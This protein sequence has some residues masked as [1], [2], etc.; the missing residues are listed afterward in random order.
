MPRPRAFS[1]ARRFAGS[2]A[3]EEP[4]SELNITPLIDVMLV[5]LVMMILTLPTVLHKVALDLPQGSAPPSETVTHPLVLARNGTVTLDGM[6]LTDAAMPA[7]F[8][9]LKADPAA[10]LVMRTDPKARYDR[11][12][13][14]LAEVKRT[15]ITRLG[16]AG[17]E[18]MVE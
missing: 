18:A 4:L 14:V 11:F 7:R 3:F 6:A 17:N 10:L 2:P 8:G 1:P 5:L 12:D 9:A 16:F 13:A 15:G